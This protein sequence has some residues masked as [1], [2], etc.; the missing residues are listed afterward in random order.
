[1]RRALYLWLAVGAVAVLTTSLAMADTQAPKYPDLKNVHQVDVTNW[2][3]PLME[4]PMVY[5]EIVNI[6][7]ELL[8]NNKGIHS[9]S[10]AEALMSFSCHG[11]ECYSVKA[12]I[13]M[14]KDGPIIWE[15]TQ[16]TFV[17]GVPYY[18]R[19]SKSV[20][21]SFVKALTADYQASQTSDADRIQPTQ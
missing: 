1:M 20:A 19:S 2:A 15:N 12:Q 8:V 11:P 18:K 4:Q 7:K 3:E 6:V 21:K 5:P 17:A 16:T 9:E 14:G 13:R 10:P